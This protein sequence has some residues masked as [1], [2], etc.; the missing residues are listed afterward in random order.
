MGL[1]IPHMGWNSLKIN[2]RSKLFSKTQQNSYVYFV[3]SYYCR[4]EDRDDAAAA[5]NYGIEFDAA[6][7]RGNLFGCQFHPEKSGDTGL[8][9]LK[10]FASLFGGNS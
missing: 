5:C 6:V 7:E 2:A 10:K 9:L 3:H 1:K 8:A 4:A